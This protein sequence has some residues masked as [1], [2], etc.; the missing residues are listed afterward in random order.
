MVIGDSYIFVMQ[1]AFDQNADNHYDYTRITCI[2]NMGILLV[3]KC[4][5]SLYNIPEKRKKETMGLPYS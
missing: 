3:R 1:P 5:A 4:P 2:C